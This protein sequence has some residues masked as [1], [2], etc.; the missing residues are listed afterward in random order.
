[1][2]GFL[3]KRH[4]LSEAIISYIEWGR[5]KYTGR[6][7]ITYQ[8]YLEKFLEEIGDK[9]LSQ[10]TL[11]DIVYFQ[12]KMEN[13]GYAGMTIALFMICVRNLIKYLYL[14]RWID[15]D[16]QL[17]PIP[18]AIS[19]SFVVA[20]DED[21]ERLLR[22]IGGIGNTKNLRDK[23]IINFLASSGVRVSELC[24][25]DVANLDLKNQ[26]GRII[27]KKSYKRR[28]IFWDDET[29]RLLGLWLDQR[30]L[31][32]KDDAVFISLMPPKRFYR[33]SPRS[34]QR[35]IKNYRENAGIKKTITPHS[36]RHGVGYKAVRARM[37]VRYLQ[38]LLGHQ[39]LE[40]SKIYM[41]YKDEDLKKEYNRV[42]CH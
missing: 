7:I 2:E 25:L 24:A 19:K 14:R 42:F 27:T 13:R 12:R 28:Q 6:T 20:E 21:R 26:M 40:S 10:L 1:M 3:V 35:M 37:Y 9:E 31:I 23:L 33:L 15:I 32:A 5:G 34:V 22:V 29:H 38:K 30:M 16:Y 41:D 36:F 39:N 11:D 17:V 4:S 8:S 18:R